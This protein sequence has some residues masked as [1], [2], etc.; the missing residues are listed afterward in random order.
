MLPPG[1][2]HRYSPT[3]QQPVYSQPAYQP[4]P[5]VYEPGSWTAQQQQQPQPP[6]VYS[7]S[8]ADPGHLLAF[9]QQ[10]AAAQAPYGAMPYGQQHPGQHHGQQAAQHLAQHQY[11]QQAAYGL[12][13]PPPPHEQ[14]QQYQQA[15]YEGSG[16]NSGSGNQQAAQQYQMWLSNGR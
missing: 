9:A 11:Q 12:A 15:V 13:Y 1:L 8:M 7:V 10:A 16:A 4:Q 3:I 6:G 5:P 2:G 14:G